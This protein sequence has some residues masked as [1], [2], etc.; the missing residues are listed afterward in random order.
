MNLIKIVT[1]FRNFYLVYDVVYVE[2]MKKIITKVNNSNEFVEN[3]QTELEFLKCEFLE[4][5]NL[6]L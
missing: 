3:A 5:L 6:N 1:V 2:N 4:Q